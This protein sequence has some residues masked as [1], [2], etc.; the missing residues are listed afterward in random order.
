M[1]KSSE[2]IF[3]QIAKQEKFDLTKL[4]RSLGSLVDLAL[5]SDS[6]LIRISL[7]AYPEKNYFPYHAANSAILA[8]VLGLDFKLDKGRLEHLALA[9]VLHDVGLVSI[10]ENL[11]YPK[12]L[13]ED[14]K[15]EIVQHPVKGSEMLNG[16]VAP[17][18]QN[19]I[20]QHHEACNGRG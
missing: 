8:I 18:V 11:D 14:I 5:Q 1:V 19:A 12:E 2:A 20:A 16:H 17:E 10:Q 15:K 13:S 4:Q 9:A 6:E 7:E 3:Q